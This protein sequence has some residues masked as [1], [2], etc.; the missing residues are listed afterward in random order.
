[1]VKQN[2]WNIITLSVTLLQIVNIHFTILIWG[3]I[4]S[5]ISIY[6]YKIRI[7]I[8]SIKSEMAN[9]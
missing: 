2:N 3:I 7:I 4:I 5:T 8:I 9:E 6:R 1:M